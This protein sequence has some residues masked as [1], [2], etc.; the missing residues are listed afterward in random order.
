M[1]QRI[2]IG[3]DGGGSYT[4][5]MAADPSGRVLA[6]SQ[7][8]PANAHKDP[9]AVRHV[10][11]AIEAALRE[12]ER[13]E[14]DVAAI[15]AGVAGLDRDE[16]R[17]WADALIDLPGMRGEKLAVNDARIAQAGALR[18]QPGII[19]IAGT[20]SIVY[21]VDESGEQRNNYQF[22]HYAYA[23]ARHLAYDA[24]FRIVAGEYA[25]E[26]ETFVRR[27]L[28]YWEAP[29]TG[30]LGGLAKDG[31]RRDR[32]ACDRSFGLMAPLVTEAAETGSPLAASVCRTAAEQ[33]ATGVRL[34]GAGFAGQAVDVALIGGVARCRYIRRH[35][36]RTLGEP[37][38]QPRRYTVV[39]PAF[40][41]AAGAVM[42]AFGLAGMAVT[43]NMERQ[44][45][46]S[47]HSRTLA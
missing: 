29:D 28:A 7:G 44:L 40:S 46:D 5:V 31:F 6:Y 33:L 2:V 43:A 47:P 35:L 8:G 38:M 41:P 30:Y 39:E 11:Q 23:A 45:A 13:S 21:G 20:G 4:R 16:D 22:R 1:D 3:I 17:L 24:V 27:V 18:G 14:A 34:I 26:D 32:Q 12:A 15:V 37:T 42:M 19:A 25:A 36:V 9:D 10:R